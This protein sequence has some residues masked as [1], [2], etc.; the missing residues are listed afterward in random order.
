MLTNTIMILLSILLNILNTCVSRNDYRFCINRGLHIIL[1]YNLN[2]TV[3]NSNNLN[4]LIK[5]FRFYFLNGF[6]G[7]GLSLF[8]F[9]WLIKELFEFSS[10]NGFDLSNIAFVSSWGEANPGDGKDRVE[11]FI[12]GSRTLVVKS[13][14]SLGTCIDLL[15]SKWSKNRWIYVYWRQKRNHLSTKTRFL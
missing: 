12:E 14:D 15:G 1:F 6:W 13:R 9:R 2:L 7:I 10:T 3:L 4:V 11:L 8:L 5:T